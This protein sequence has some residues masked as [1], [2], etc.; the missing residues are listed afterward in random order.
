MGAANGYQYLWK[1]AEGKASG[2]LKFSWL[3]GGRY[4]TVTASADTNTS[5]LFARIGASDPNF[6]LRPE[7]AVILRTHAQSSVFASVLEPHGLWDGNIETSRDAFGGVTNVVVLESTEEYTAAQIN[8]KDGRH[9]LVIVVN[10]PSSPVE[11]HTATVKGKKIQWLGGA[12][13]VKQ[14]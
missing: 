14:Q 1:E 12:Y 6:N 9:W 11:I 4:Y 3:T 13:I 2:S 7:A 8:W 10:K 5:V